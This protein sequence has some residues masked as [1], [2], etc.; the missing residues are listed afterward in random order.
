M[1]IKLTKVSGHGL[2]TLQNLCLEAHSK[3]VDIHSMSF[4]TDICGKYFAKILYQKF[5]NLLEN[6]SG[7][8]KNIQITIPEAVF[9]MAFISIVGLN[10]SDPL[11][12]SFLLDIIGT[13]DKQLKS[14][15]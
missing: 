14:I 15:V 2:Q 5:R 4:H 3:R 9:L 11:Q 10:I 8:P 1:K 12:K 13:I 6:Y 7:R